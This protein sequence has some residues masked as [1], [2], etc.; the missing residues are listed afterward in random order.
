MKQWNICYLM[1]PLL[2]GMLPAS[3]RAENLLL[4]VKTSLAVDDAQICV[5]PNLALAALE[6]GDRVTMLFD[7]SAVTSITQGWGWFV[8]GSTTPMDKAALPER[9]RESLAQQFDIP[10]EQIPRNY[11]DYLEFIRNRGA[12]IYV[13]R[14][15][16]TLY[17]I[18]PGHTDAIAQPIDLKSMVN[19]FKE[20]D[21]MLVY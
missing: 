14:T 21:R 17:N 9:E 13:N 15:M 7:G 10:L 20:A 11:G 5:A 4:H 3:V 6:G 8:F 2:L 19:L 1:M 16:L 12:E 18:D